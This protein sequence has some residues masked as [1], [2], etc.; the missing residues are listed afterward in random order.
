MPRSGAGAGTTRPYDFLNVF[1]DGNNISEQQRPVVHERPCG[2]QEA[3]AG[4]VAEGPASPAT[5]TSRSRT[6]PR[7]PLP[8]PAVLLLGRMDPSAT[9]SSRS[10]PADLGAEC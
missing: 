10:G 8:V 9:S 5:S 7:G 4:G 3:G 6:A 2:Q 1:F